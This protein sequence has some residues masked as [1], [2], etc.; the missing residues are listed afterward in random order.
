MKLVMALT[1]LAA[2]F[3]TQGQI[4]LDKIN[5]ES[6]DNMS[7]TYNLTYWDESSYDRTTPTS[8]YDFVNYT[9][10]YTVSINYETLIINNLEIDGNSMKL[11]QAINESHATITSGTNSGEIDFAVLQ[12]GSPLYEKSDDRIG[13]IG[14]ARSFSQ[15]P[16][17]GKWLNRRMVHNVKMTNNPPIEVNYT[18][19]EMANWHDRIKF[20][21]HYT[22]NENLANGALQLA[23]DMPTLYGTKDNDGRLFTFSDGHG[24]G[25]VIKGGTK[26]KDIAVDGNKI[27]VATDEMN[28][29][30]GVTY[31]VSLI[32]Y[33]VEENIENEYAKPEELESEISITAN[34]TLP[35]ADNEID[36]EYDET[37]GIHWVKTNGYTAGNKSCETN[38]V[39]ENVKLS[40][41]NTSGEVKK[42]R[43]GFD[44]IN[45]YQ[46]IGWNAI[47]RN[48]NGDPS[49]LFLQHSKNVTNGGGYL[50]GGKNIKLFTEVVVPA[51]TTLNFEYSRVGALW[52]ET[53]GAYNHQISII[54]WGN[55]APYEWL[56]SGLGGYGEQVVH[57]PEGYGGATVTDWRPFLLHAGN[58]GGNGRECNWTG[59]VGG[60][61]LFAYTDESN[62]NIAK[63]EVKVT[64]PKHG[65]NLS[66]TT[67]VQYSS[68]RKVKTTYTFY[69]NRSDDMMRT[70]YDLKFEAIEN[71]K[72]SRYDFFELGDDSYNKYRANAL[73]YGNKDGI[74]DSFDP[75]NSIYVGD[76][77]TDEIALTGENP[78][79]WA[80]DGTN[81]TGSDSNET[82]QGTYV[83]TNNGF[84]VRDYK[85]TFGGVENNIPYM[86][87]RNAEKSGFYPTSYVLTTPP[88]VDEFKAGDVVEISVV[89]LLFPKNV[90]DYYGPNQN[91]IDAL[92]EYG[93]SWE[94]MYREAVRND[95]SATSPTEEVN[96]NYP[97]TVNTS[98]NHAQVAIT[99]GLGYVPVVFK[100]LT[101]ITDP[102]LWKQ[103]GC[104]WELVDQSVHGKDFWQADYD[105]ET[106]LFDLIYNVNQDVA[107]DE[108]ATI[109]YYLGATPPTSDLGLEIIRQSLIDGEN[110]SLNRDIEI[111]IIDSLKITL[112]PQARFNGE[113]HSTGE[114]TWEGPNG[115]TQNSK[116]VRIDTVRS[117]N[118]G[119]YTATYTIPDGCEASIDF[120]IKYHNCNAIDLYIIPQ[121]RLNDG[122]WSTNTTL[123]VVTD[124]DKVDIAPAIRGDDVGEN[125]IWSWTGPNGFSH[126]GR[127]FS[128]NPIAELELGTYTGTYHTEDGCSVGAT[129][130]VNSKVITGAQ[131]ILESDDVSI[132]PNPFS[133]SFTINLNGKNASMVEVVNALGQAVTTYNRESSLITIDLQ[134]MS[135]GLYYVKITSENNLIIKEILKN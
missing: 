48:D 87:E 63:G 24:K 107:N 119:V 3:F 109:N 31:N 74:I 91:F 70:F 131:S 98:G 65:P 100:G 21:F 36:V 12:N 99:G 11:P 34:Q 40:L 88:D 39:F 124:Q 7:E 96:T 17:Y 75:Q 92:T 118:L 83:P 68:D 37:E 56:Q 76:Y 55:A 4:V 84:I 78:W 29:E 94:M 77:T 132:Y 59:G 80:G 23:I 20:T 8:E 114:W 116:T 125:G 18:G 42:V 54:G 129:F 69:V 9:D 90:D 44:I 51:N 43:L 50:F 89:A 97:L 115:F 117:E 30:A 72:F 108:V 32:L 19:I 122:G 134:D 123:E 113:V 60:M 15:L 27:I 45:T 61:E 103:Q 2:Q 85:A 41:S 71:T 13:W 47:L 82:T 26:V 22:A 126:G 110:W 38:D 135:N 105:T 62:D 73:V 64:F 53:Y 104:T 128:L 66:E 25:F 130:D 5:T 79:V 102:K 95:I 86:R 52:G 121:T 57:S 6:Y 58:R 106:G 1:F 67:V 10:K 49:G 33:V 28:L 133:E 127:N 46:I 120:E 112:S 93:N 101:D 14:R 111:D 81:V 16:H 35:V